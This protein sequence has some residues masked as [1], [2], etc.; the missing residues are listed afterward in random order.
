[1]YTKEV[2]ISQKVLCV[3]IL[4]EQS[5]WTDCLHRLPEQS[6]WID[7]VKKAW[8]VCVDSPR[9]QSAWTVCVDSLREQS[10]WTVYVN[11]MREQ[12]AWTVCVNRLREQSM[13]TD[14]VD[15]LRGEYSVDST[16]WTDCVD[17]LSMGLVLN[18]RLS[19]C[20]HWI[21][22]CRGPSSVT[23]IS[24]VVCGS[25]Y[26]EWRYFSFS[27]SEH[28]RLFYDVWWRTVC[29]ARPESLSRML[30]RVITLKYDYAL[31]VVANIRF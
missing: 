16:A 24:L 9:G 3:N 8:T 17:N 26:M 25:S 28:W 18:H 19:H 7:C 12:T 2:I 23:E 13:W 30:L 29:N 15:S 10:A 20:I 22:H 31:S 6:E 1:M 11:N 14:C 4:C 5:A 27:D 21:F